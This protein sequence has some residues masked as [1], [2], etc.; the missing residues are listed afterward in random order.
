MFPFIPQTV[1]KLLRSYADPNYSKKE[2][3]IED[4][5]GFT[6]TF[7]SGRDYSAAG[8]VGETWP[9]AVILPVVQFFWAH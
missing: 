3:L 6:D 2:E 7:R 9:G 1:L 4:I 5:F 8:E